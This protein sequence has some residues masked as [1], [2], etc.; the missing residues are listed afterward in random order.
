MVGMKKR[1]KKTIKIIE[2][3][4]PR[5]LDMFTIDV[6]VLPTFSI[7]ISLSLLIPSFLSLIFL[8]INR[9]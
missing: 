2:R 8:M 9:A 7:F 5:T 1:K 4:W 6:K 3:T